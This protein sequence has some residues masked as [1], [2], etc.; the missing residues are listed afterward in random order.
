[1]LVTYTTNK[2]GNLGMTRNQCFGHALLKR[3]TLNVFAQF[4]PDSKLSIKW[5]IGAERSMFLDPDSLLATFFF[6]FLY[7]YP[8]PV[9]VLFF[10]THTSPI[11]RHACSRATVPGG[12]TKL[13]RRSLVTIQGRGLEF[14][15]HARRIVIDFH[16]CC[17]LITGFRHDRIWSSF[18]QW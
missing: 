9:S 16:S 11:D 10:P 2:T 13:Q 1:M 7:V 3:E 5:F 12:V 8:L 4:S 18:Y 14:N 15:G 6:L 17:L